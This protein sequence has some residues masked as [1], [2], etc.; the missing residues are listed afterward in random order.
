MEVWVFDIDNVGSI[1]FVVIYRFVFWWERNID[2]GVFEV[3]YVVD[4]DFDRVKDEYELWDGE[5]EVFLDSLF[6]VG[7][8]D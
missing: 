3:V 1:K 6:E 4:Y 8:G 2:F 5:F 7:D